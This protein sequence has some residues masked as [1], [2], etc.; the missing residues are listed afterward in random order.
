MLELELN[1][2]NFFLKK[3]SI[4][5]EELIWV[6][7]KCILTALTWFTV[8]VIHIYLAWK[9]FTDSGDQEK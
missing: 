9:G 1:S 6:I 5:Q 3:G 7:E 4:Y 2:S 8:R